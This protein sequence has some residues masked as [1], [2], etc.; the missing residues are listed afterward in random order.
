MFIGIITATQQH[1]RNKHRHTWK[2]RTIMD[3][4][5]GHGGMNI[6]D[7]NKKKRRISEKEKTK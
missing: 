2:K 3:E 4:N 7:A 6:R 5:S 1:A